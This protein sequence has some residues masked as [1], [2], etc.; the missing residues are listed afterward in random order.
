MDDQ[1]GAVDP[2]A[3]DRSAQQVNS[4]DVLVF[5]HERVVAVAST[6]HGDVHPSTVGRGV[7]EEQRPVDGATLAGVAGLGVGELDVFIHV[8]AVDSHHT[9][10][11]GE[12]QAAVTVD[13][14]DD[15]TVPV[16]DHLASVRAF[17][18]IVA[19]GDDLV[20]R[21][22]HD[23]ADLSFL[24]GF[25]EFTGHDPAGLCGEVQRG[26]RFTGRGGHRH[27]LPHRSR[28]P[29][30]V[31]DL[32]DH[33]FPVTTMDPPVVVVEADHVAHPLAQPQARVL[34][35]G[36]GEAVD[37]AEQVGAYPI[38]QHV[39]HAATPDGGELARVTHENQPPGFLVRECEQGAEFVG[40]DHSGLV[41]QHGRL[42]G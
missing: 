37:G 14:P 15:P 32:V 23:V 8:L 10:R 29:P 21:V 39:E 7:E 13:D 22:D 42:G 18:P 31:D 12:G 9:G 41:H 17:G 26:D 38:A 33:A 5:H 4:V 3:V 30:A 1:G 2:V 25:V 6:G 16:L 36:F 34:F 35:P 40:G 11:T 19:T 20:T 27:G 28:R 24:G